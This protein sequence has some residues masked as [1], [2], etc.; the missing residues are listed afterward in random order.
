MISGNRISS[1]GNAPREIVVFVFIVI[2][3]VKTEVLVDIKPVVKPFVTGMAAFRV[4]T[5]FLEIPHI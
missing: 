4:I 3:V 1:P 5:L 2:I